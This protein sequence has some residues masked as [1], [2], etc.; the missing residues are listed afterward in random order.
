[1]TT[2]REAPRGDDKRLCGLSVPLGVGGSWEK[3]GWR[4]VVE[5]ARIA[6]LC[7]FHSIW[8]TH[9]DC[10]VDAAQPNPVLVA[11]AVSVSTQH[12]R[13][14]V[15]KSEQPEH[16]PLRIAEDWS[17][18][19]NLSNARVELLSRVGRRKEGEPLPGG[20]SDGVDRARAQI[21]STRHLWSGKHVLRAGPEEKECSVHTYPAPQHADPAFWLADCG[22]GLG[23]R[24]SAELNTGVYIIDDLAFD[25][26]AERVVLSEEQFR[27]V[28]GRPGRVAVA[29]GTALSPE[30]IQGIHALGV[31]E[32]VH[33]LDI[34]AA[35]GRLTEAIT[36][37]AHTNDL[38]AMSEMA[39]RD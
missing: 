22:D 37:L 23:I 24:L 6:E 38:M 1:M 14:R 12:I 27:A 3:E 2:S 31:E 26:I 19:D 10:G 16:D 15:E 13:V 8:L 34:E 7:G 21:L 39:R 11:A 5:A 9:G 30:E 25:Q 32:V 18:V 35:R 33:E 29:A 17:V 20:H 36:E 28:N 4:A